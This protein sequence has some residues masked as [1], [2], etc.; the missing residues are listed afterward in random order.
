MEELPG[1]LKGQSKITR[2]WVEQLNF[3]AKIGTTCPLPG[4]GGRE[5]Q[6][7][8]LGPGGLWAWGAAP[9]VL[10]P[11]RYSIDPAVEG[12]ND[13]ALGWALGSYR[14]TRYKKA[15][16][17]RPILVWPTQCDEDE[18]A[19]LARAQYLVR[20]LINTPAEDMGPAELVQAGRKVAAEHG[21]KLSVIAGDKLLAQNYPTI[22][23]VGRASVR[24]PRLIDIRWGK[25]GAPKLTLIGKGVCFDSGGLDIKPADGMLLMKKDMGGA[26]HVL[27]LAHLLMDAKLPVRLRVLIP[28]VENAIDGNAFRPLDVI[29]TRSGITVEVGNTDAEGRLVLCDAITEA[30]REEPDLIV[31]FATLTGAARIALGTEVPAMFTNDDELASSFAAAAAATNDPLWRM[32]L[33]EPYRRQLDSKVADLNNVS[34]GSFGGA[35]TAA[36]FLQEFVGKVRWVHFDVMAWNAEGQHG[37]PIGGEAMAL[38]ATYAALVARYAKRRHSK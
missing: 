26:A 36:L 29:T 35:I 14:F 32:P 22:H 34:K 31:D 30:V 9:A 17:P 20:D 16:D 38:R 37:R 25:P 27:G 10:P 15:T 3:A 33:F 18:V 23:T 28:A 24:L 11:G 21:A 5:A 13:I 12:G 2:A 8:G 19:R 4:D 7:L 6:L 1:W